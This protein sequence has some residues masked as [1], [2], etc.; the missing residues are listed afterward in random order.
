M[1]GPVGINFWAKVIIFVEVAVPGPGHYHASNVLKE[2]SKVKNM[3][4]ERSKQL[5][6]IIFSEIP[7]WM[8][9]YLTTQVSNSSGPGRTLQSF[10]SSQ[11]QYTFHH[12][13]S[14]Q[15]CARLLL[16]RCCFENP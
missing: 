3:L 2:A 6:S 15:K 11:A 7:N 10:D 12:F 1:L 5:I 4:S 16:E 14:L 9:L 13:R 8:A